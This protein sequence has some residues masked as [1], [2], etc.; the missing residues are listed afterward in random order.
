MPS[1]VVAFRCLIV[2][3]GSALKRDPAGG[4][5]VA[6]EIEA[7]VVAGPHDD[8]VAWIDD[9]GRMLQRLPGMSERAVGRV[10]AGRRDIERGESEAAFESFQSEPCGAECATLRGA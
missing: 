6:V 10:V 1:A 9:V 7:G 2:T 3:P 5:A 4:R 8:R